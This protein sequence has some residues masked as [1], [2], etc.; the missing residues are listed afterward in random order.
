[1]VIPP[2]RNPATAAG[3]AD[4]A[5]SAARWAAV[6]PT[7]RSFRM[8]SHTQSLA[9]GLA[10]T[11]ASRSS[12]TSNT[13]TPRSRIASQNMS[14]SALAR[15]TQSTSSKSSSA[16]L[17]RVRRVCYRPGRCPIT[18]RSLPASEFTPNGMLITSLSR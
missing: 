7:S 18:W 17:D 9:S 5:R 8:C 14:C 10:S 6:M 12:A 13:S 15:A 4:P 16:A 3:S 1:L 2:I 11:W